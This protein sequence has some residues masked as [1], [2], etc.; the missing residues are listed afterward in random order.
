MKKTISLTSIAYALRAAT[1]GIWLGGIVMIFIAA[2]IVFAALQP[3]RNKAGEIVGSILH[4]GLQLKLVLA[5]VALLCEGLIYRGRRNTD[6]ECSLK[7]NVSGWKRHLPAAFLL[8]A[9][10]VTLFSL[11][12][13]EPHIEDLRRSIGTFTEANVNSPERLAFGKIHG[14]SMGLGL[15]EGIFIFIAL[16]LGLL[17]V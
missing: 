2:P 15:L 17:W 9:I 16:I 6:L 4:T 10:A 3:D 14:L 11:C 8:S 1:L 5:S 13:I 12:W 7:A